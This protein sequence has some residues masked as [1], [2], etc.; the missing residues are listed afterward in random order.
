MR[1]KKI[2][3]IESDSYL[4]DIETKK[5][6]N[7]F[8]NGILVHNSSCTIYVRFKKDV[9]EGLY[10]VG[11]CSRNLE[12]KMNEE[13]SGNAFV[14]AITEDKYFDYLHYLGDD[15]AIQGELCGPGIQGNKYK[16]EKPTFFV[17][18]VFSISKQRYLTREE[19]WEVLQK[20]IGLGVSVRQVPHL[21]TTKIPD[22]VASCLAMAEG[23]SKLNPKAHREGIVFKSEC[24]I[25][26]EVPSF[27]AISNTFLLKE[28]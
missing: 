3:K 18:D 17:F 11:I 4:F 14:R 1:L 25:E 12:L 7:F 2:E 9:A 8:A 5:N 24:V 23:M 16:L 6:N 13:N 20:L 21:G 22:S 27:K 28:G 19:R 15:L 10:E 26:N